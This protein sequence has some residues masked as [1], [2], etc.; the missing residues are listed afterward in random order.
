MTRAIC[1]VF[2]EFQ[3]PGS[4]AVLIIREQSSEIVVVTAC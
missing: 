4:K 1:R 3:L 2:G